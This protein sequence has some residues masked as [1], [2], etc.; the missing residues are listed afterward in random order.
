[1]AAGDLTP[2]VEADFY[3]TSRPRRSVVR[4]CAS[5]A[6]TG[7]NVV[8]FES[9]RNGRLHRN[10]RAS[11]SLGELVGISRS[12]RMPN[13]SLLNLRMTSTSALSAR[14]YILPTPTTTLHRAAPEIESATI[15]F[16]AV[17]PC[18]VR[19]PLR[20]SWSPSADQQLTGVLSM[21][22]PSIVSPRSP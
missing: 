18:R 21:L 20:S 14:C 4:A 6:D 3:L 7:S 15:D 22:G 2:P 16:A 10:M 5:T 1:M 12:R 13:A 9:L 17:P 19:A 8:I 11:G